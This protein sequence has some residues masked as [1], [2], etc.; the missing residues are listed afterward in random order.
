[1]FERENPRLFGEEMCLFRA[2]FCQYPRCKFQFLRELP[3]QIWVRV[4]IRKNSLR[5]TQKKQNIKLILAK[6]RLSE[7]QLRWFFKNNKSF[8]KKTLVILFIWLIITIYNSAYL[9]L[10]SEKYCLDSG[11]YCWKELKALDSFLVLHPEYKLLQLTM[12]ERLKT[13]PSPQ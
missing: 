2:V 7:N 13:N 4:W 6:I 9:F 11:K 5:K 3:L 1:M 8:F 12:S 10:D